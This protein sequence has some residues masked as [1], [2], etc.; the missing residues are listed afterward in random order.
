MGSAGR[1]KSRAPWQGVRSMSMK[2][3]PRYGPNP[4]YL[5]FEG[6]IQDVVGC[7]SFDRSDSFQKM[8]LQSVFN[9]E[10]SNW[11]EVV[12]EVLNLSNTIDIAILDLWHRNKTAFKDEDGKIDHV[13]FSQIFTDEYM[14]EDSQVDIWQEG[15]LEEA[16][17][18][19]AEAKINEKT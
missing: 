2:D 6:F 17:K 9:T 18:R 1:A 3:H 4:I 14:K 5:F 7:L 19:I 15:A 13:W 8:N 12:S 11:K 16:K 10:A